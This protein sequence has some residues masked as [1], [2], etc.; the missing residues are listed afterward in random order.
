MACGFEEHSK[1]HSLPNKMFKKK[2]P[3]FCHKKTCH[4]I[5]ITIGGTQRKDTLAIY[6]SRADVN[7]A[8]ANKQELTTK[9]RTAVVERIVE[10]YSQFTWYPTRDQ[11]TALALEIIRTYPFLKDKYVGSGYDSWYG[12]I[13]DKFKNDR[14]KVPEDPEVVLHKRKIETS[15][16]K[17]AQH[18][19]RGALNWEP[20]YPEGEDEASMQRHKES[21]QNEW[22][23][24][25]PDFK[26]VNRRMALTF[27]DRRRL[28]N[29]NP[30][31]RDIQSEYPAL[32]DCNQPQNLSHKDGVRRLP[33]SPWDNDDDVEPSKGEKCAVALAILPFLLHSKN[34]K[35]KEEKEFIEIVPAESDIRTMELSS[36]APKILVS[37]EFESRESVSIVANGQQICDVKD[38]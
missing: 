12:K 23:R 24:R 14:K 6:I 5:T 10:D 11:M 26:K 16:E 25:T 30:N 7:I 13:A 36:K 18:V 3:R 22:E 17:T 19:R 21:L 4:G 28:M 37:G 31:I 15:A 9:L 8:L 27:P 33:W 32:F 29:S 20:P 2:K 34:S 38:M 1:P 35:K